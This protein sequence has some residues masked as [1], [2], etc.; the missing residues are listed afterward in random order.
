[1]SHNSEP[2]FKKVRE[3][4]ERKGL[5]WE[6]GCWPKFEYAPHSDDIEN[7]CRRELHLEADQVCSISQMAFGSRSRLY[8][9]NTNTARYVLKVV[10]PILPVI[11]TT[12]EVATMQF[13]AQKT[14]IP[15]PEVITYSTDT[16]EID[17]E[18]IL[19]TRLPGRDLGRAGL[20]MSTEEMS[21]VVQQL[22]MYQSELYKYTFPSIGSLQEVERNYSQFVV[23]SS[24]SNT[25][26]RR[27][28]P[29]YDTD[30]FMLDHLSLDVPYT[31]FAKASD[32]LRHRL[33][34]F[35]HSQD[36]LINKLCSTTNEDTSAGSVD[37]EIDEDDKD[38]RHWHCSH[39]T[40]EEAQQRKALALKLKALVTKV[41][42]GTQQDTNGFVLYHHDLNTG[43]I[44]VDQHGN[45]TSI[46]DWEM[47]S[48][49]PWWNTLHYPY[50][51][52]VHETQPDAEVRE[53][54]S[55][56]EPEERFFEAVPEHNAKMLRKMYVKTMTEKCLPWKL[57]YETEHTYRNLLLAVE[58]IGAPHS[59]E[60]IS[61]WVNAVQKGNLGDSL[62]QRLF[63][64]SASHVQ[65]FPEEAEQTA[66]A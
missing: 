18:W 32:W 47:I 38:L 2:L 51:L 3:M 15:V 27:M 4:P 65:D 16:S 52:R 5:L 26:E 42:E 46:L 35:I 55:G 39:G 45:V 22:T 21:R 30:H 14:S 56:S 23:R 8:A 13:I 41:L 1:M 57:C 60:P 31:T 11:K 44:L 49:V 62:E 34:I 6:P 19:M 9:V 28:G 24:D 54:H 25:E 7:L 12:S 63:G 59:C 40:L 48:T 66:A 36:V 10:L 53:R 33:D 29:T 17:F 61:G 58:N 50:F 43:N 37:E 20:D 64:A